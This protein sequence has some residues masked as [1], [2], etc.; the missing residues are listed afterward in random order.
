MA[1]VK[2]LR[3]QAKALGI[4]G[5]SRMKKALLEQVLSDAQAAAQEAQ[6]KAQEV[7]EIREQ[8]K[9]I[10]P[11]A[12]ELKSLRGA[13]SYEEF[14]ALQA[15]NV[16]VLMKCET[17]SELEALLGLLDTRSMWVSAR[18]AMLAISGDAPD[19]MLGGRRNCAS[20][21]MQARAHARAK[22]F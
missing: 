16:A 5:Y 19:F 10:T 11:T 3:A 7:A 9:S 14:K 4:K 22:S 21:I 2:E 15:E 12:M 8:L 1:T 6:E 20:L 18:G 17:L 13:K